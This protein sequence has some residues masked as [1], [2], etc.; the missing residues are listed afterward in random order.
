MKETIIRDNEENSTDTFMKRFQKDFLKFSGVSDLASKLGICKKKEPC[1]CRKWEAKIGDC[2]PARLL[3]Q[4]L[5][6]SGIQCFVIDCYQSSCLFSLIIP[7]VQF[8][9]ST[10]GLSWTLTKKLNPAPAVKA[11]LPIRFLY[12]T[13]SLVGLLYI[14]LYASDMLEGQYQ[15]PIFKGIVGLVTLVI[16][17]LITPL[18]VAQWSNPKFQRVRFVCWFCC[19]AVQS[20]LF[21]LLPYTILHKHGGCDENAKNRITFNV[22][23]YGELFVMPL[24]PYWNRAVKELYGGQFGQIRYE[25]MTI[26]IKPYVNLRYEMNYITYSFMFIGYL[27]LIELGL[28][29]LHNIALLFDFLTLAAN[30]GHSYTSSAKVES[31]EAD[32][33][34]DSEAEV[35]I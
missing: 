15:D 9:K 11:F 26:P 12:I 5:I 20:L 35:Q 7:L 19:G 27:A 33:G 30:E 32:P 4:G 14:T 28:T 31:E 8:L 24:W 3:D 23:N 16:F 34:S 2:L 25:D 6:N 22:N 1:R 10:I 29:T 17:R 21:L 18:K 13:W